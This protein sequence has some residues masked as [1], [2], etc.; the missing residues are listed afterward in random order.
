MKTGKFI[1][2]ALFSIF[3]IAGKSQAEITVTEVLHKLDEMFDINSDFSAKVKL[4]QKKVVQGMKK[5]EFFYNRRDSDDSFLMVATAPE[6]EKG[7]GYLRVGENYWMYRRNTR[8]FQHISRDESISGTEIRGEN[9]E[10]R[11]MVK[12]YEAIKDDKGNEIYTKEKL[13]KIPVYK[14]EIVSKTK[15]V[16]YPKQIW[17]VTQDNFLPLR[18]DYFS[19]SGT[20]MLTRY[21]LKYTKINGKYIGIKSINV[22]QFEKGNKTIAEISGISLKSLDNTIFTKAYLENLSK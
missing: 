4:V 8:T 10:K 18:V 6:N 16:T 20:L 5:M 7:N 12:L 2:L 1:I 11:K 9:F 21:I 14:F 13:G 15:D 3:I 22:D 17:W 19:L